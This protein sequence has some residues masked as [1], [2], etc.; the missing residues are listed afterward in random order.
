M[1]A[2]PPTPTPIPI[3]R[4][5]VETRRIREDN[6]GIVYTSRW[7]E[8][9]HDAYSGRTVLYS[10]TAGATVT[11]PFYGQSVAW[12]GPVGPTRGKAT[13]A[14]DGTVVATVDLRRG[15]FTARA[16]LF[17]RSWKQTGNHTVTITVVGNGRP[18]AIDEFVITRSTTR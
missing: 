18:V 5:S 10:E 15:R 8:A 4:V 17:E 11:Y 16:T 6:I 7:L 9:R 2:P 12:V 14:V 1:A 3:G 13:V